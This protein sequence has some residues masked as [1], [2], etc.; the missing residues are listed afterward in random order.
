M[1]VPPPQIHDAGERSLFPSAVTAR[2][3]PFKLLR[4]KGLFRVEVGRGSLQWLY[5]F[6]PP[7]PHPNGGFHFAR[8]D[9][10]WSRACM[11]GAG[12]GA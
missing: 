6:L 11:G 10:A 1:M 2:L 4:Q 12:R 5:S 9:L 8:E 7:P 3:P